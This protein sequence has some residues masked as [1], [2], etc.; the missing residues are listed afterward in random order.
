MIFNNYEDF[1]KKMDE[2][3]EKYKGKFGCIITFN[4]FVRE[5]D[6]KDGEKVPS[7]GMHI[8]ESILEELKSI[9]EDAKDKFDLIEVLFY[10][11]TGFLDVGE[12]IASI[13]VFAKHRKEG[14]EAL[15][16]IINEMKKYH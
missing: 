5:Y 10:H 7:K 11:N 3:V 12:R 9:V 6:L 13:A 1:C 2:Y 4:G 15:E 14:F 8:D 16:Y